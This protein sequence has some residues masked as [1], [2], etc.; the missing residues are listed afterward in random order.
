MEG[1][2]LVEKIRTVD[3]NTP[4]VVLSGRRDEAFLLRAVT[5]HLEDF[6]LE[7]FSESQLIRSVRRCAQKLREPRDTVELGGALSYC[8]CSKQLRA[9]GRR[10]SLT[11][12]EIALLELLPECRG[13]VVYYG[14][15][16]ERV[17]GA[18][19]MSMDALKSTVKKL[20]GKLP[21]VSL[22]NVRSVGYALE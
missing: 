13:R 16:E 22:A 15:I 12:K 17:W 9:P 6:L 11:N 3:R 14:E 2:E 10:T 19:V 21:G 8:H 7:P 20:R 1:L 18:D 4:I 5:L